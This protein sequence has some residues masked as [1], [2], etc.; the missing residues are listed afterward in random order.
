MI[1]PELAQGQLWL[2]S[3]LHVSQLQHNGCSYG[4]GLFSRPHQPCGFL[5]MGRL[6][7][8]T[9]IGCPINCMDCPQALLLSKYEGRRDLSLEDFKRAIDK[10]PQGT[11][12]DFSGMCEPFA[13]KDC[14]EMIL[15]AASKGFPL[16][17]YTTLQ[18]ATLEDYEKLKDI[19]YEVVTIHL[20][21]K[22]GRSHFNITDEYL[23]VL[24]RWNT[25]NYSCHG[26]IDERVLP[27]LKPR[28]LITF[29]HDR[30]GNVECRPHIS[31]EPHGSLFCIT[32][33]LLMDHNVLLP[34][35]DVLMCCMDYGMTGRFGNLFEQSYDEVLSSEEACKM[36]DTL[37]E[38]ESIC[39][40]C[41]NARR[42]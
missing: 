3:Y 11:R 31:I 12:I 6:E 26:H 17:L 21:D 29:M 7:I 23:E 15:Y 9:H 42:I 25:D 32:S 35:G 40:H 8:T 10:V 30:A 37:F 34:N 24:W 4:A 22:D 28:N 14:A 33:G 5:F 38:G 2:G 18:G 41:A 27:Y 16:A 1:L 19:R 36:R 13:N 39:R 20:P